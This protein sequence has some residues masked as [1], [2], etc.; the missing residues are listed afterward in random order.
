VEPLAEKNLNVATVRP[1]SKIPTFGSS[2]SGIRLPTAIP[3]ALKRTADTEEV[4]A[5]KMCAVLHIVTLAL[6][7]YSL[8]HCLF[9]CIIK[10]TKYCY[11]YSVNLAVQWCFTDNVMIGERQFIIFNNSFAL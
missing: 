2:A 9:S 8:S 3:C 7:L 6:K 1:M 10:Y 4:S 5:V 11:W